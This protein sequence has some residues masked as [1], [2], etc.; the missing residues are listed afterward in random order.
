M[1]LAVKIILLGFAALAAAEVIIVLL[2]AG[3]PVFRYRRQV[4]K[5]RKHDRPEGEQSNPPG[6]E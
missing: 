6:G 2:C 1:S 3:I 4:R 5:T